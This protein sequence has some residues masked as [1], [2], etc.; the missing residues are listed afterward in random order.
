LFYS[1]NGTRTSRP[2]LAQRA[3]GETPAVQHYPSCFKYCATKSQPT[4]LA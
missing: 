1:W 3:A 2:H 4:L